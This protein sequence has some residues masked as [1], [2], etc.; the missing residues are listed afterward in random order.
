MRSRTLTQ[1]LAL[2]GDRALVL[3][4]AS[5]RRRE[6]LALLGVDFTVVAPAID[7]TPRPAEAAADLVV[8]LAAEKGA[9]VAAVHPD[10]AV[11]AADTC[12]DVGGAVVGKPVDAADA[13]RMLRLLGGR[14][15]LVHTGVA[16]TVDGAQA[17]TMTT[18]VVTVA[19]LTDGDIDWYVGT[20][21]PLDKAGGYALQG[22]GGL[23]VERVDGSV[24]GVL[25]LPLH[26]TVRLLERQ[27]ALSAPGC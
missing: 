24:S 14:A 2:L 15:H 21:E 5:P 20:G 18:S 1:S 11:I 10:A 25:G 26:E 3:A 7:E 4:S 6:L 19:A 17:T 22:A 23:F 16:V 9:V 12:L 27:L 8:R 13:H